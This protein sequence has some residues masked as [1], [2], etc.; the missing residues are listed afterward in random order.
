MA[1]RWILL[2][3]DNADDERMTRR[4]FTKAGRE[5]RLEICRDGE[6][7]VNAIKA[8][9][10]PPTLILLDLKLPRLD[11]VEVLTFIREEPTT[12]TVPVVVLTSSDER[13]DVAA[14]YA[15]GANAFVRKPIDF[16]AYMK[17]TAMLF[18]FW[19][20]VNVGPPVDSIVGSLE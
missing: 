17:Q 8:L 12:R 7:A 6:E 5:E 10:T 13:T 11:G 14:C 18:E 15:L 3:E 4:A 1:E 19:M 9:S 16:D 2:V 20:D